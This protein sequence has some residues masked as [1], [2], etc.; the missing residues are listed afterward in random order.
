MLQIIYYELLFFFEIAVIF[1]KQYFTSGKNVSIGDTLYNSLCIYGNHNNFR[2]VNS[3]VGKYISIQDKDTDKY[4]L[5]LN[6]GSYDYMGMTN[7]L[8]NRIKLVELYKKYQIRPDPEL[9]MKL[10]DKITDFLDRRNIDNDTIVI[11]GGYQANS[12]Y[13]P[14][15]LE[16]QDLALSQVP[17]KFLK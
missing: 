12:I 17:L 16:S 15:I 14:L 8:H 7:K 4:S 11:N 5:A 9:I 6:F 10:E 13:L 3:G 1:F 2:V